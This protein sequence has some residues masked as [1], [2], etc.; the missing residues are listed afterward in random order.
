VAA[1]GEQAG[2]V[3]LDEGLERAVM[4]TPDESDETLV[5]LKPEQW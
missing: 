5:A 3:A 4:P 1:E 2:L